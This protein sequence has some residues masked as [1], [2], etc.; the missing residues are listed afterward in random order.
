[1]NLN[2]GCIEIFKIAEIL[3]IDVSMNLNKG[4][5]EIEDGSYESK[6]AY[7]WTLTRVV[8]KWISERS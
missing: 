1:M 8:L 6:G 7:G 4:C 5:I 3:K 2:K